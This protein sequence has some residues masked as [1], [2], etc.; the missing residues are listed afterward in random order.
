MISVSYRTSPVSCPGA[1]LGRFLN[2]YRSIGKN[3]DRVTGLT[4][5]SVTDRAQKLTVSPSMP[6]E[7]V[8][9]DETDAC[10]G[11]LPWVSYV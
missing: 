8:R 11:Q 6:S 1:S 9:N 7:I 5:A 4:H 2:V 10:V 3:H